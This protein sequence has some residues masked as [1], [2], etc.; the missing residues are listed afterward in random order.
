MS[1]ATAEVLKY[2]PHREPFLFIDEVIDIDLGNSIHAI[3]KVLPEEDYLRGHFPGNPIM[4]GV[5]IIEALAQASGILGFKTMDKTPQE[6]SLYVFAG[7]DNV[8][9]RKR[10]RPGDTLH[11]FSKV[12]NV[13]RAYIHSNDRRY[14][15]RPPALPNCARQNARQRGRRQTAYRR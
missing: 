11:L 2:L 6:G 12:V 1:S 5:I 9:F 8:R 13:K 15:R 3:K 4:P 7:V 14:P 10:V